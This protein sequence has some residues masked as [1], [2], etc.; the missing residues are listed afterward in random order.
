ME[1]Q[2][3]ALAQVSVQSTP[4]LAASLVTIAFSSEVA[5]VPTE[6]VAGA[7]LTETGRIVML[8]LIDFV[9]SLTEVA[10]TVTVLP[11]GTADGAV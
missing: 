1:P 7:T 5:P 9:G 8:A 2:A 11:A 6:S 3:P 4:A 10:V